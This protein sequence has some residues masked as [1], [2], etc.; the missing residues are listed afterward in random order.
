[1]LRVRGRAIPSG[2]DSL[3]DPIDTEA[4]EP[5]ERVTTEER[6][7]VLWRALEAISDRCQQLLRVL[8]ADPAP[9][10]EEVGAALEMPIG[11]I[12]PTRARCLDRLRR[13]ALRRGITADSL[14]S[15]E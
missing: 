15:V 5:G 11:S 3:L 8:M 4:P 9:S 12:G 6:D 13:E 10:Y 1:V 7:V 14:R 2:D